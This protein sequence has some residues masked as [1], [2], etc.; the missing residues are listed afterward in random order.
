MSFGALGWVV[1]YYG[2]MVLS[3]FNPIFGALGYLQEYY[4]RPHLQWWDSQIP[5]TWRYNLMISVVLAVSFV[6]RRGSLRPMAPA[7]N[8]V[9][10]WL[11]A[12]TAVMVLVSATVA[13]NSDESWEWA[14][15]WFKMAVIFPLL[16]VGV[17]RTRWG[18][19]A[20]S[21][22]HIFGAFWWGWK[23][24]ENPRRS[25][26]RLLWIG[27]DDS[28]NDNQAATHLLTTLPFIAVYF[29]TAREKWLRVLALVAAPLVINTIILCNSRG[30][31]VGVLAGVIAS[32]F[33][34]RTGY[35]VRLAGTLVCALLMGYTLADP[36]FI[37]R[38]MPTEE[39][40]SDGSSQERLETWRGAQRLVQDH[41]LGVGG[42]G[43]HR[44]S[45][46]YIP[47]IVASHDGDPR[48]PHNTWVMVVSEWGP[49]GLICFLG[50]NAS[51]FRMMDQLK[52]KAAPSEGFFYWR[53]FAIQVSL[54]IYLVAAVFSDRLYGE[55]GYWVIG[56]ACALNRLKQT[57]EME[58]TRPAAAPAAAA[59]PV[60]TPQ[61]AG[62]A[63]R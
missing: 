50:L 2:F 35:R 42:R 60:L 10:P 51:A 24:W 7:R 20:I 45:Y 55:A 14:I 30:A 54:V 53:A 62:T 38:Q 57:E 31:T 46:I 48:A 52:R 13:V 32:L 6:L 12:M 63:A 28:F 4:V 23:A 37:E 8:P 15:Q 26:G 39:Y 19:N 49:L 58:E 25:G 44:L 41:P 61:V 1:L 59:P 56:L 34:I 40:G 36:Q 43:F 27:S 11:V 22:A 47:E 9:L 5:E 17:I 21:G 33:L 29:L 3:F 16:L 18:F